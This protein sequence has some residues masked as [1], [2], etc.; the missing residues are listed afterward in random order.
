MLNTLEIGKMEYTFKSLKGGTFF[1][2][3]DIWL[4]IFG[5]LIL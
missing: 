4:P 3:F 2:I 1:D 5:R